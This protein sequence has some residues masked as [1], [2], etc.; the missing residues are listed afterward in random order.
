MKLKRN[1]NI[2]YGN[3]VAYE[4]LYGRRVRLVR[5]VG[6]ADVPDGERSVLLADEHLQLIRVQLNAVHR[7]VDSAALDR[8]QRLVVLAAARRARYSAFTY[9]TYINTAFTHLEDGLKGYFTYKLRL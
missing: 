6:D 1:Q 9:T 2:K 8:L 3:F 4:K 5:L 7:R